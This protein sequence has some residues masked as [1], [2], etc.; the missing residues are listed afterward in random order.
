MPH[1]RPKRSQR[2]LER[3]KRGTDLPPRNDVNDIPKRAAWI[4]G[5]EKM[6]QERRER[7]KRGREAEESMKSKRR[8]EEDTSNEL[9]I[10]PGESLESF[11]RR[12]E[13]SFRSGDFQAVRK[14]KR[15]E[16]K[17]KKE[18][19]KKSKNSNS[20]LESTTS[21]P[22]SNPQITLP[23]QTPRKTEFDTLPKFTRLNDVVLAPPTLKPA[24]RKAPQRDNI[25]KD[26]LSLKDKQDIEE[27]RERVIRR[28]RELKEEK[29]AEAQSKSV[30]AEP[31]KQPHSD[32]S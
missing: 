3:K 32:D 15:T 14:A 4:F 29:R 26:V 6:M 1:K 13:D 19:S 25:A 23:S 27:E 31:Q 22:P 17:T 10:R 9:K 8:K 16:I 5:A 28:Y 12:V 21:T 7:Q 11:D 20:K 30:L 2:E 24:T 18:V